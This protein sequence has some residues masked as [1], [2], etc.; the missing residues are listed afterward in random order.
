[1]TRLQTSV[2][3]LDGNVLKVEYLT[4]NLDDDLENLSDD[5][6]SLQLITENIDN[7]L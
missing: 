4:E 1:M 2:A 5:F 7:S 3:N 6:D